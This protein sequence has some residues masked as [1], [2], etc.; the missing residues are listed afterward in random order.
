ML[1]LLK[2]YKLFTLIFQV[3]YICFLFVSVWINWLHLRSPFW[4]NTR[5]S[6][7]DT[8]WNRSTVLSAEKE[9][10]ITAMFL[11]YHFFV[12]YILLIFLSVSSTSFFK[13]C[14][15]GQ[16]VSVCHFADSG[17]STSALPYK[18]TTAVNVS[19]KLSGQAYFQWK[20]IDW[21]LLV[22]TV[23]FFLAKTLIYHICHLLQN[24]CVMRCLAYAMLNKD[25]FSQ[26]SFTFYFQ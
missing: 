18:I 21:Q 8:K 9:N 6:M 19:P 7:W 26:I 17:L 24:W 2:Q 3:L 4:F 14:S 16:T 23:F 25:Y 13:T 5:G 1:L 10:T 12:I 22:G 20:V 15:L 11:L